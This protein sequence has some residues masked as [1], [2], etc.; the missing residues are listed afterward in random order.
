MPDLN[1]VLPIKDPGKAKERLSN[2]L[3]RQERREL[4]LA[5]AEE[6][7]EIVTELS[8]DPHV[9]VVTDSEFVGSL[10][11]GKKATVLMEE[12]ALGETR[13]IERATE[14]SIEN[15]F[16]SQL[17]I[18]GDLAELNSRELEL[19][20]KE[21]R[22]Y[23]SLILCPAT[24]DDGTNAVLS[25]PPDVVRHRYGSKSFDEFKKKAAE[26]DILCN[27]LRLESLVLDLDTGDDLGTFLKRGREDRVSRLLESWGIEERF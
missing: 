14:W 23:P 17:V 19:L 26:K 12:E 1:I 7:V 8:R 16:R 2:L 4:S 18:P 20:L 13:A 22:P 9:L 24:G 27:V 10:M 11:K 5:L 6:V 3:T 25:T 15:K 21:P